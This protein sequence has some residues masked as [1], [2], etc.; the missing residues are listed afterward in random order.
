MA[1]RRKPQRQTPGQ[2]RQTEDLPLAN[3][4]RPAIVWFPRFRVKTALKLPA[5]SII[6]VDLPR[7]PVALN[8]ALPVFYA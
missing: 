3:A 5:F 6:V 8:L 4:H 1:I 7:S 2:Q